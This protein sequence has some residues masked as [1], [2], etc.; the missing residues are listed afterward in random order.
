M[1]RYT[2]ILESDLDGKK[3]IEVGG[4]KKTSLKKIDLVTTKVR[5]KEELLR[6]LGCEVKDGDFDFYITYRQ[7]K[8]EK[9]LP[10]AY[11]N[12]TK[13]ANTKMLND[14]LVDTEDEYFR[15][16]LKTFLMAINK[17]RYLGILKSD[18]V[19]TAKLSSYI[20]IWKHED[21]SEFTREK[22]A[23]YMASYKQMRD[24]I[25]SFEKYNEMNRQKRR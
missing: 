8:K 4:A 6:L 22:V 21:Q 18:S 10:I 1:G 23:Y 5:T 24:I 25:F 2:L 3:I 12:K 16:I 15:D 13:L 9:K 19:L 7:D 17:P 11:E 20:D 14:S